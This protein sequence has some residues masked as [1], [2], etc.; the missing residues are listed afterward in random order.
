MLKNALTWCLTMTS[1]ASLAS[2]ADGGGYYGDQSGRPM[3]GIEMSPPPLSVQSQEGLSPNEGVLIR[4]VFA[5]SAAK[6]MGLQP[7]D[8]ILQI[9]EAPIGSMSDLRNEIGAYTVGDPVQVTISRKGQQFTNDGLL[10]TWPENIPYDALDPEVERRFREWQ[11]RRMQRE[12]DEVADL[13]KQVQEMKD[14]LNK[15]ANPDDENR[16]LKEAMDF[17]AFLPAWRLEMTYE[18]PEIPSPEVLPVASTKKIPPSADAWALRHNFDSTAT[19]STKG[20]L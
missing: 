7:G 8:V 10:Q 6:Q 9:N 2:A 1:M 17:L 4:Q 18:L 5:N 11:Q 14:Q 20:D 15:P 16:A 19:D 13:A 12:Q 3:L